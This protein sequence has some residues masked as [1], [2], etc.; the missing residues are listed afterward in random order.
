MVKPKPKLANM[1]TIETIF[2]EHYPM[3]Q[4]FRLK[5]GNVIYDAK[6]NFAFLLSD[7][8]TQLL[9]RFLSCGKDYNAGWSKEEQIT[10]DRFKTLCDCDIFLEGPAESVSEENRD[11]LKEKI[12]YFDNYVLQRKF[13]LEAT[14]DC[15]FRCKYC[16]NT[17]NV[18]SE[19]RHHTHK[20]MSFE[21]A[22]A[23]IDYYYSQYTKIFQQLS[24]EKKKLLLDTLP[25]T[26][27]WYG[28]E[29]LL[30]FDVM[31][32]ATEYFKSLPWDS[33]GIDKSKLYF[34]TNSNMSIMNDRILDFLVS[35]KVQLFASL[36]GPKEENDKC[37]VFPNGKGTYDII[38]TNLRKIRERDPEYF[39]EH[40]SLLSVRAKGYNQEV[41]ESFFKEGEFSELITQSSKEEPV[42]CIYT[43][44]IAEKKQ[45]EEAFESDL[46][47]L[48]E[49]ID[50]VNL[51]DSSVQDIEVLLPYVRLRTDCPKG[52]QNLDIMLTCPMGID[53]NMISVNG[54]IHICHKTDGSIPFANIH[55]L[56]IDYDKL[57][58]I[59]VE[60]NR[61]VNQGGCRSCWA[62]RF[63]AVCGA[64][65]LRAGRMV[66][67][68]FDE[69]EVI[70]LEQK[71]F[72]SAFFYAVENRP[73]VIEYLERKRENRRE[74]ISIMDIHTF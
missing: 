51:E 72:M 64:S 38:A 25:P 53:N 65:R 60:H 58:D 73:D 50:K 57:V 68:T 34:S 26:L 11:V 31:E 4:L 39:K 63:C 41:C 59:Y 52:T 42:G 66:N 14:E 54:D 24:E 46:K 27:S 29:P 2:K 8:E 10:I 45:M 15:N 28:G 74:Y 9:N 12:L 61:V 20:K 69:C 55:H 13:V 21:T 40:V 62:V 43:D 44:P 33:I 6:A 18:G 36:D 16:P 23:A 67:P 1:S 3:C 19:L 5:K 37:R 22:K 56:P 17:I 47:H 48:E 7:E 49:D 35:N 71:L 70:R 32:Q 30:N